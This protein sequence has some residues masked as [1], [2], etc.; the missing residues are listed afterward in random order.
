VVNKTIRGKRNPK[1]DI[2]LR[3]VHIGLIYGGGLDSLKYG[4]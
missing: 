1:F 4:E 3:M 2:V